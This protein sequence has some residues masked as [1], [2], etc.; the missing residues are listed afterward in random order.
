MSMTRVELKKAAQLCIAKNQ[1]M[2]KKIEVYEVVVR[3]KIESDVKEGS[4]REMKSNT[5]K[6]S[7]TEFLEMF[8]I[9]TRDGAREISALE[10]LH[11]TVKV[12]VELLVVPT[13]MHC[14]NKGCDYLLLALDVEIKQQRLDRHIA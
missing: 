10:I 4:R 1:F 7:L 8:L 13:Q 5:R 12:V 3:T 9:L 2:T 6:G 14:W 11:N